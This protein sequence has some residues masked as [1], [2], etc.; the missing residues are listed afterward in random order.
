MITTGYPPN[1]SPGKEASVSVR[2]LVNDEIARIASRLAHPETD[3]FEFVC[4]C[5]TLSCEKRVAM[6]LPE[7]RG[8][9]PGSVI[10]H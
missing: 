8:L 9:A 3:T 10:A 2:R 6:T 5:G 1:E 7:Y 4:E